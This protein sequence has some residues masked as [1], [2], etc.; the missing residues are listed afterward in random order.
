MKGRGLCLNVS[1]REEGSKTVKCL[2]SDTCT[3]GMRRNR[4]IRSCPPSCSRVS[5]GEKVTE[6]DGGEQVGWRAHPLYRQHTPVAQR[7]TP[8]SARMALLVFVRATRRCENRQKSGET[9]QDQSADGRILTENVDAK[10]GVA[11]QC[12]QTSEKK[13]HI[14]DHKETYSMI[15]TLYS[16]VCA[17]RSEMRRRRL[18]PRASSRCARQCATGPDT[19]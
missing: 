19:L 9:L 8:I 12:A 5:S 15:R 18:G 10:C 4:E 13:Q 17:G 14:I 2:P 6:G 7:G 11:P 16:N 3:L 1:E